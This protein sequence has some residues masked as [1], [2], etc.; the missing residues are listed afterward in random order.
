MSLLRSSKLAWLMLLLGLAGGAAAT[1][2]VNI[3]NA[4]IGL[5]LIAISLAY[6]FIYSRS[7]TSVRECLSIAML[8]A[9]MI[10]LGGLVGCALNGFSSL[11]SILAGI[12]VAL[13]SLAYIA[14]LEAIGR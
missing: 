14:F 2:D 10:A 7:Y 8:A 3:Q 6:V 1:W 9:F 11:A 5:S 13:V 4:A 12:S